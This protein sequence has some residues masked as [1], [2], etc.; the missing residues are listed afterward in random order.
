M[1]PEAWVVLGLAFLIGPL[2]WLT[3]RM[4]GRRGMTLTTIC[5]WLAL[6]GAVGMLAMDRRQADP[7]QMQ[8]F[9]L[10]DQADGQVIS[11]QLYARVTS[12]T[13]QRIRLQQS[14][15]QEPDALRSITGFW[16]LP[17]TSDWTGRGRRFDVGFKQLLDGSAPLA[18]RVRPDATL[19]MRGDLPPM[20]SRPLI[21]A[22]LKTES[23]SVHGTVTNLS[24]H[25]MSDV[26]IRIGPQFAG[27]AASP[28]KSWE[29]AEADWQTL[30]AAPIAIPRL[31]PGESIRIDL[32]LQT[33][34]AASPAAEPMPESA[35]W[36]VVTDLSARRSWRIDVEG[37]SGDT[38][39]IYSKYDGPG[40]DAIGEAGQQ[41]VVKR[42]SVL[43]AIVP[44]Q[45]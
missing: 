37:V 27:A 12:G 45:R 3:L 43:R 20:D 1:A 41:A 42:Q 24:A 9:E 5:G 30:A 10:I 40:P 8:T 14:N 35:L 34:A 29:G 33:P 7:L 25:L 4:T 2:D 28:A 17:S 23:N 22:D 32:P 16:E 31:S 19:R 39:T 26:R 21:Q 38:A 44:L 36:A 11:R 6:L 13:D 15:L 18:V